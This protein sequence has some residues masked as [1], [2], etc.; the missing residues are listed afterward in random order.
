MRRSTREAHNLIAI[1]GPIVQT[2]WD[3]YHLRPVTAIALTNSV[4]LSTTREA[5]SCVATR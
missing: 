3:P 5:T 1:C 2:L 4:E